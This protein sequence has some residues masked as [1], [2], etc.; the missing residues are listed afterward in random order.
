MFSCSVEHKSYSF[1]LQ[2]FHGCIRVVLRGA[3]MEF[4]GQTIAKPQCLDW[5]GGDT[6]AVVRIES[7][8]LFLM[9]RGFMRCPVSSAAALGS[10]PVVSCIAGSRWTDSCSPL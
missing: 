4:L 3:I 7:V 2:R 1:H 9:I 8:W 6:G 5:G 10:A